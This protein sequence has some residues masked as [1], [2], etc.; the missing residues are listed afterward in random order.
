MIGV[1]GGPSSVPAVVVVAD[2]EARC[3]APF[4]PGQAQLDRAGREREGDLE[5]PTHLGYSQAS[6]GW[7]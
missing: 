3:A 2:A 7:H 4:R 1:G 5:Q 6:E